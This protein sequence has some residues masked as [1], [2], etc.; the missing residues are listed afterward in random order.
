MYSLVSSPLAQLRVILLFL[1]GHPSPSRAKRHKIQAKSLCKPLTRS[2]LRYSIKSLYAENHLRGQW[3]LL[4]SAIHLNYQLIHQILFCMLNPAKVLDLHIHSQRPPQKSK[5][6]QKR[7]LHRI[8]IRRS[9][10]L[11]IKSKK[12][13]R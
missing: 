9:P 13:L 2:S 11:T 8:T 1:E 7:I 12:N 10:V 5:R 4:R 3:L 6:S